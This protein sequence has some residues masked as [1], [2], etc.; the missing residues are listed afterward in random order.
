[1]QQHLPAERMLSPKAKNLFIA[2]TSFWWGGVVLFAALFFIGTLSFTASTKFSLYGISVWLNGCLL[3]LIGQNNRSKLQVYHDCMVIW[4]LT[5]LITNLTWEIPWVLSS[6]S[7]FHDLHT[8]EDLVAQT[9]YMREHVL[10][11][12]YW[13]MASFGSVDLRT[14]NHD[15]TFFS[16]ECLAFYNVASV[17]YFFHLNKIRSKYRYFIPMVSGG[18]AAAATFIFSFSEVFGGFANMPGGVADTLLA[19]V[20]TQY[21]YILFPIVFS[22]LAYHL[23][24]ADHQSDKQQ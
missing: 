11:M 2:W 9:G 22:Y 3:G 10:H 6:R 4:M 15:G 5:Y 24:R 1:M 20:W 17:L 7:I 21:Q 13:V 19:L 14:V 23:W 16:L 18:S 8:L 12:Y